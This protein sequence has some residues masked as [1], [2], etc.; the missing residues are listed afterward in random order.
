MGRLDGGG[1]VHHE[2]E[3][4]DH[5][6]RD[7]YVRGV[8]RGVEV[9]GA[10]IT[11]DVNFWDSDELNQWNADETHG[12]VTSRRT[13]AMVYLDT[14][15]PISKGRTVLDLLAGFFDIVEGTKASDYQD[16]MLKLISLELRYIVERREVVHRDISPSNIYIY[17]KSVTPQNP[18]AFPENMLNPST[19]QPTFINKYLN[20]DNR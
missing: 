16:L 1:P 4:L 7:G 9:V 5:I 18:A 3:M 17:V 10:P 6:H 15:T 8:V 20:P 19:D 13:S 12:Q 14:G 2:M 11:I